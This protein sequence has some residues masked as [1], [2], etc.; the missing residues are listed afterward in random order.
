[1][2]Q[3]APRTI[4]PRFDHRR[5]A[6]TPRTMSGHHRSSH[7]PSTPTK[8]RGVGSVAPVA[9]A[10][11]SPESIVMPVDLA[12]AGPGHPR[13]GVAGVEHGN[14]D[15]RGR[16]TPRRHRGHDGSNPA[17]L[18]L[19]VERG[20]TAMN[21]SRHCPGRRARRRWSNRGAN[22]SGAAWATS[23]RPRTLAL[24]HCLF[25]ERRRLLQRILRDASTTRPVR[26]AAPHKHCEFPLSLHASHALLALNATTFTMRFGTAPVYMRF[27]AVDR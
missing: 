17:P 13:L 27:V 4:A 21:D 8:G 7:A 24:G 6:P 15:G 14:T 9:A 2:A 5:L 3:A 12:Q 10:R 11:R 20:R 18:S 23:D 22:G 25:P 26:K 16:R 19:A 1:V